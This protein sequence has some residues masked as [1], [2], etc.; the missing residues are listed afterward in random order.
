MNLQQEYGIFRL[1]LLKNM[2]EVKRE[3]D[4]L[5]DENQRRFVNDMNAF[6][7]SYGLVITLEP[8]T[9]KM[10]DDVDCKTKVFHEESINRT[11]PP[12]HRLRKTALGRGCHLF[13]QIIPR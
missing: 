8:A 4:N 9:K 2:Q 13:L 3:F 10:A 7:A 6:L 12:V 1:K 11:T 5:S